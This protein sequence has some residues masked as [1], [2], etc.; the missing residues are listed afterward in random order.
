MA[1]DIEKMEDVETMEGIE[2]EDVNCIISVA[3]NSME[4]VEKLNIEIQE[5]D[6]TIRELK[7]QNLLLA[8]KVNIKDNTPPDGNADPEDII[9]DMFGLGGK[10]NGKNN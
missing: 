1:Y 10:N 9:R 5:K 2:Q 4:S 8:K 7:A 6:K 3:R